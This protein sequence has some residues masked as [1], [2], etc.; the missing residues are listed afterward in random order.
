MKRL[1][2]S[3]IANAKFDTCCDIDQVILEPLAIPPIK[4]KQ[5][6]EGHS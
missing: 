3:S 6:L 4:L 2:H 1:S 5:L